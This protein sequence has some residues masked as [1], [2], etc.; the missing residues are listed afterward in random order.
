MLKDKVLACRVKKKADEIAIATSVAED[1]AEVQEEA[2]AWACALR[3][4]EPYPRDPPV[5]TVVDRRT[6]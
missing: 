5:I 3:G 4:S 2:H 1:A 6:W